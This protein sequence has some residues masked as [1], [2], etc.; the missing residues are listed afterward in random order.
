MPDF[1]QEDN[2]FASPQITEP[3]TV[4]SQMPKA[5]HHDE[6]PSRWLRLGAALIDSIILLVICMPAALVMI[7][8]LGS[9][10]D[11][12]PWLIQILSSIIGF[13]IG[14]TAY[15]LVNGYMLAHSGQTVG[16]YA[17]GIKIVRY[18][19]QELTTL[20]H[21]MLLRY[22]PMTLLGQIPYI[23]IIFSLVDILMIFNAEKRCMH[24]YIAG[25]IVVKA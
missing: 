17:C 15:L 9:L 16:K 10:G 25:T 12:S 21:L 19:D 14:V 4:V 8:V 24:D 5:V 1:E 11:L 23:G 6:L 20:G 7:F 18:E 3:M 2:P 13:V 22:T